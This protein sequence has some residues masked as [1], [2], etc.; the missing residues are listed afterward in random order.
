M[1]GK[2]GRLIALGGALV[3]FGLIGYLNRDV[4]LP[5][6]AEAP[7]A[8]ANPALAACLARR[9][10]DIDGMIEQGVVTTAQASTFKQRA[11]AMCAAQHGAGGPPPLP[12]G[13]PPS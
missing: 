5:G 9:F 4:V 8:A 13:L 2:L 1:S 12:S 3:C 10:A 6:S 7:V 11:E